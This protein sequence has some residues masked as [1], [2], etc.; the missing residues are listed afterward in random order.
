M[1]MKLFGRG[2]LGFF[3]AGTYD[4]NLRPEFQPVIPRE[5]GGGRDGQTG[6]EV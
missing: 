4:T 6:E 1:S 5:K 3:P 2:T